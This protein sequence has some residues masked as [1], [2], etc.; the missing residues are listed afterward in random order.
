M[1]TTHVSAS[2]LR[3]VF[4]DVDGTLVTYENVLPSSA[5]RAIREARAAG[6]RVYVCTG[7]SGR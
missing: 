6:H 4:L 2:V 7:R 5:V 1:S 3:T